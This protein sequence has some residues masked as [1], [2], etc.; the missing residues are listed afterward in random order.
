MA[1][2]IIENSLLVGQHD[3]PLQLVVLRCQVREGA[4]WRHRV[5]KRAHAFEVFFLESF[6]LMGTEHLDSILIHKVSD[7]DGEEKPA[8]VN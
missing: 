3:F 8:P 6:D 7:V 5:Q 4:Q 2:C 1:G